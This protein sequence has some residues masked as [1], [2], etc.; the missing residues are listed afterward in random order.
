VRS[1][2]SNLREIK[3]LNEHA[4]AQ[5]DSRLAGAGI[6][7]MPSEVQFAAP[8]NVDSNSTQADI[9]MQVLGDAMMTP[10]KDRSS[11]SAIVPIVVTAPGESLDKVQHMNFWS[12]LDANVIAMREAAVKRLALGLDTPPEVLMGVSDTNHWN[13]WM[14]DEAAIKSHLEPRLQVLSEALTTAFI[15]PAI[16]GLVDDPREYSVVADTSQIRIRPNRSNEAI[17]LYDRGE[18]DGETLRRETGFYEEN[19][20]TDQELILWMLRKI[21]TGSTS[22]E[23][24]VAALAKLGAD[25]RGMVALEED[26]TQEQ[27]DHMRQDRR[28]HLPDT[29]A[30]PEQNSVLAVCESLVL[31]ALERAGNRIANKSRRSEFTNVL[32]HERHVDHPVTDCDAVMKD[33]WLYAE[34]VLAHVVDE[35]HVVV[36]H[37]DEYVRTLLTNGWKHESAALWSAIER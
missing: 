32:A 36:Q 19:K 28:T 29:Q 27:P 37:L 1:N 16:K 20:P 25:L 12:A 21:A 4:A 15:R 2:I 23:Q 5:L 24:S 10:I 7:F 30:P 14:I 31:R 22:P 13:A 3:R 34:D 18:L 35:P 26:K 17:E 33:A 6:L 8:D 9:F 11:A